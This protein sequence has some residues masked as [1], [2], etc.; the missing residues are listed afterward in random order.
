MGLFGNKKN[1]VSFTK[2]SEKYFHS[3][4]NDFLWDNENVLASGFYTSVED[5]FT[6][7]TIGLLGGNEYTYLALTDWRLFQAYLANG[8]FDS[9]P[10]EK[11]KIKLSKNSTSFFISYVN[12]INEIIMYEIDKNFYIFTDEVIN[13]KIPSPIELTSF[14]YNEESFPPMFF[15]DKCQAKNLTEG[16]HQNPTNCR[17]CYRKNRN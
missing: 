6:N 2:Y 17:S 5:D 1:K 15:C 8:N 12:E 9:K 11:F 14:S 13:N 7:N 4:V 16:E 3:R 10:Y